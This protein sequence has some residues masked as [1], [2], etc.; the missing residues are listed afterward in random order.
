MEMS[1]AAAAR[2]IRL[3]G[4]L[5][6]ALEVHGLGHGLHGVHG[7]RDAPWTPRRRP[8]DAPESA[9]DLGDAPNWTSVQS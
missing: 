3:Y 1:H 8:E 4:L 9:L 7:P 6:A 2:E 5:E